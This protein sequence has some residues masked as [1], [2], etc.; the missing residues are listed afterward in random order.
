MWIY[1]PESEKQLWLC[2]DYDLKPGEKDCKYLQDLLITG[3]GL[4]A[5]QPVPYIPYLFFLC[6][7]LTDMVCISCFSWFYF[8]AFA[9]SVIQALSQSS[10]EAK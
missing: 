7:E 3:L 10:G 9:C 4:A 1:S 6:K 2:G 8:H 5:G